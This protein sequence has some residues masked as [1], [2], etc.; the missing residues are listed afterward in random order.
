MEPSRWCAFQPKVW[1]LLSSHPSH[2]SAY[3]SST[4]CEGA[5]PLETNPKGQREVH[6]P[7]TSDIPGWCRGCWCQRWCPALPNAGPG[8]TRALAAVNNMVAADLEGVDFFVCNTD[9]QVQKTWSCMRSPAHDSSPDPV[10]ALMTSM[11]DH[12]VL[13]G[14]TGLGAGA[15]PDIG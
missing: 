7:T 13:L 3:C 14:D 5:S 10:E 8:L 4:C 11:C 15:K 9:A 12:R 2:R 6:C 1:N